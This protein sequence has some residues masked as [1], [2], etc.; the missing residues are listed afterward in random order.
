[1][2]RKFLGILKGYSGVTKCVRVARR[3]LIGGAGRE[4]VTMTKLISRTITGISW[5]AL[6]VTTALLTITVARGAVPKLGRVTDDSAIYENLSEIRVQPQ[7]ELD[8]DGDISRLAEMESSYHEHLGKGPHTKKARPA[9]RLTNDRLAA[10]M[11]RVAQ[12]KYKNSKTKA[13]ARKN[14]KSRNARRLKN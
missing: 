2:Y 12:R 14:S 3:L 4:E 10:P 7:K 9:D 1:M 11:A 8:L 6:G 5:A 13:S